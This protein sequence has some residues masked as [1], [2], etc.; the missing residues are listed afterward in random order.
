MK[1]LAQAYIGFTALLVVAVLVWVLVLCWWIGLI[2]I[3][4]IVLGGLAGVAL[5][6][7]EENDG[8]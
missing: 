7:L 1:R 6:Y 3:G 8:P 5:A 2:A 4:A